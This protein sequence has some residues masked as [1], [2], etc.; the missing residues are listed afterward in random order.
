MNKTAKNLAAFREIC[1]KAIDKTCGDYASPMRTMDRSSD[2]ADALKA[3][4]EIEPSKDM[5]ELI[6]MLVLM[7]SCLSY[8]AELLKYF[9]DESLSEQE[10][11]EAESELNRDE[12]RAAII[13][14][15]VAFYPPTIELF[16]QYIN[17]TQP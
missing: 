2:I 16:S 13:A 14:W 3:V 4:L 11:V 1:V 5:G 8:R 7:Q 17:T 9:D 6:Y 10:Q 12:T 15:Q